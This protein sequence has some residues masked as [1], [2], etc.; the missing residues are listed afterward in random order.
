MSEISE[1]YARLSTAFAA[2]VAAVP[3]DRW[4]SPS[5]CAEWTT[6]DVVRHVVETQAMFLGFVDK[7]VGDAPGVDDDPV[8]AFDAARGVVQTELDD[9]ERAAASFEGFGGPTTFEAAVDRFLNFD[10]VVHRWDLARAAGLDERIDPADVERVAAGVR[11]FG[12]M[13]YESGSC[14]RPLEAPPDADDQVR[15]LASVGRRAWD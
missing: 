14:H 10:L 5:P 11:E 9:P 7:K 3:A 6:R 2:T 1:R 15:M 12:D 4:A 8:A 13:L